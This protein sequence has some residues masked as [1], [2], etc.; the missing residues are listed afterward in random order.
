MFGCLRPLRPAD[1]IQLNHRRSD[2][3]HRERE[4]EE[5]KKTTAARLRSLPNRVL[6]WILFTLVYIVSVKNTIIAYASRVE[7]VCVCV[8]I[9]EKKNQMKWAKIIIIIIIIGRNVFL[10]LSSFSDGIQFD[11]FI[12]ILMMMWDMWEK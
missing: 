9:R 3:S 11:P 10:Y 7:C 6:F 4:K 8:Y 12:C 5:K 1:I 2:S